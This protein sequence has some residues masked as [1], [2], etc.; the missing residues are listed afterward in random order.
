[1]DLSSNR[2]GDEG[3]SALAES[4]EELSCCGLCLSLSR[5]AI[6]VDGACAILAALASASCAAAARAEGRKDLE[7]AALASAVVQRVMLDGIML[8]DDDLVPLLEALSACASE[9]RGRSRRDPVLPAASDA[10]SAAKAEVDLRKNGLGHDTKEALRTAAAT[11][12]CFV[13]LLV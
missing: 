10:G 11:S 4:F 6:G 8:D 12:S 9:A 7:T 5:N 1:M 13:R 3:A 2:I